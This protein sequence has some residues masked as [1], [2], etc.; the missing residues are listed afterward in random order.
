MGK[1]EETAI[2]RSARQ[3]AKEMFPPDHP[4]FKGLPADRAW[5]AA[6]R[7]GSHQWPENTIY[8]FERALEAGV[9][10]LE[11][12]VRM[13]ADGVPVIMHDAKVDRTTN[14]RGRVRAFTFQELRRF[15]A[16]YTWSSPAEPGSRPFQG[17]GI[18]VPSLDEVFAAFPQAR[19]VIEVKESGEDR[20]VALG[21]LIRRYDRVDRTM[22]ASFH[23]SLL[24]FFRARYPEVATSAGRSEVRRFWLLQKLFLQDL[25]RSG[26][27]ALQV[28]ERSRGR[29]VV[30]PGFVKAARRKGLS[31]QI[32]TVNKPEA[33][34]RLLD[35]GVDAL[36]TDV[37]GL[38]LDLTARRRR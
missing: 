2:L 38:A 34:I 1:W 14:G 22:V 3:R 4:F 10:M 11:M 16:A 27:L 35:M 25:V 37:P 28:P 13:T 30:T 18:S 9:H 12:D 33:M 21:N 29:T 5:V 7:G 15:D 31:L 8:A 20:A 26:Y 19:M 24:Q 23:T 36:I 17:T 32:W 6:H